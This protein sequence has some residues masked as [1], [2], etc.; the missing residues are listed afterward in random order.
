MARCV[1]PHIFRTY[2]SPAIF[3]EIDTRNIP[4]IHLVERLGFTRVAYI[5]HADEF[6]GNVS[7]EYRYRLTPDSLLNDTTTD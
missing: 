4:S 5:P 3:A 6:K 1:L 7:N 2:D